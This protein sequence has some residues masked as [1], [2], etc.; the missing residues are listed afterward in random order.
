MKKY[1]SKFLCV[2]EAEEQVQNQK[3]QSSSDHYSMIKP[4]KANIV[5][6]LN[7]INQ[8]N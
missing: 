2:C 1:L 3:S 4:K 7:E 5:A 6:L 8:K